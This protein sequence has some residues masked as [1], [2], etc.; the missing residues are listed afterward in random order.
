LDKFR[1]IRGAGNVPMTEMTFKA[2]AFFFRDW[3]VFGLN[4]RTHFWGH[5]SDREDKT[6]VGRFKKWTLFW[7]R[8]F[9]NSVE[10][11]FRKPCPRGSAEQPV[12]K[13]IG[14]IENTPSRL[15]AKRPFETRATTN[16][17][18]W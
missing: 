8:L 10:Q 2:G 6:S 14:V 11:F 13:H 18:T 4:L 5:I 12:P 7:G 3:H 1:R 9:Q 16:E 15:W 17:G